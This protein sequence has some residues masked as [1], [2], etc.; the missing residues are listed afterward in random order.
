MNGSSADDNDEGWCCWTHTE[1]SFTTMFLKLFLLCT[2]SRPGF[3]FPP[4]KCLCEN[5][6]SR[7]GYFYP[8][9]CEA[10]VQSLVATPV[11]LKLF[12]FTCIKHWKQVGE[13]EQEI[14]LKHRTTESFKR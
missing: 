10:C 11:N 7:L 6:C 9:M 3:F 14:M 1:E 12:F 8:G 4:A 13:E 2:E 5:E